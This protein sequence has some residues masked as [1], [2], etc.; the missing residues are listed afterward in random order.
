MKEQLLVNL[1]FQYEA[2]ILQSLPHIWIYTSITLIGSIKNKAL[3]RHCSISANIFSIYLLGHQH[4]KKNLMRIQ[5]W[6][7]WGGEEKLFENQ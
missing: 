4:T 5:R 3:N 7:A 1:A 2:L 6:R